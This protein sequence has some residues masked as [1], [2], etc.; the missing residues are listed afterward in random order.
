MNV[1]KGSPIMCGFCSGHDLEEPEIKQLGKRQYKV[2]KACKA[3][4]IKGI[5]YRN[6]AYASK[7]LGILTVKKELIESEE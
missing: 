1:K 6:L 4:Y 5:W 2:C 3:I 7:E